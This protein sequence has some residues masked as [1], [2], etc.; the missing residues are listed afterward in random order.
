MSIIDLRRF[1]K[2]QDEN[3]DCVYD[4]ALASSQL[5]KDEGYWV[6]KKFSS[7][8]EMHQN[9]KECGFHFVIMDDSFR[10]TGVI[11][12]DSIN[13]RSYRNAYST[14]AENID[15]DIQG[16]KRALIF[17]KRFV[18]EET[19]H[20]IKQE[21]IMYEVDNYLP[22]RIRSLQLTEDCLSCHI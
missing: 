16:I 10:K 13:L 18:N 20:K 22:I 8:Q 21:K 9:Y 14:C 15:K 7:E 17:G 4:I 3:L 5:L 12:V 1:S 19:Y 6:V 2:V 11:C